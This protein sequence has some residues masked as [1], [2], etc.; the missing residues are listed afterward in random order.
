[1]MPS[2]GPTE[3]VN[4][5]RKRQARC[6]PAGHVPRI[7][8][9]SRQVALDFNLT[10]CQFIVRFDEQKILFKIHSASRARADA[11]ANLPLPGKVVSAKA[12]CGRS[13]KKRDLSHASALLRVEPKEGFPM[14][15]NLAIATLIQTRMTELGL[16]RGE[17]TKRL[18][19]K[20]VAK[21]IRHMELG[22]DAR[23]HFRCHELAVG[24]EQIPP[25]P[26]LDRRAIAVYRWDTRMGRNN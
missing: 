6:G 14:K 7:G 10:Y 25:G 21:G 1:M 24:I 19:Y 12:R 18:G 5:E 22:F 13:G 3:G 26:G 23:D 4:A 9:R 20:N 8:L 15:S 16:S 11:L 17:F 2:P